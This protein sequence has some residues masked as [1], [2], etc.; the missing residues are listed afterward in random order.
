MENRSEND[1]LISF[2]KA[3]KLMN[4]YL[5]MDDYA[6]GAANIFRL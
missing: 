6:I 1:F 4:K 2:G 3:G 5:T